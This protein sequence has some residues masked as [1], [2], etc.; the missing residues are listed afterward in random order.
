MSSEIK[1]TN[2]KHESSSSNNLVL[3]S[4][5]SATIN[6]ISST[7]TFPF[8]GTTDAGRVIQTKVLESQEDN[9]L[10]DAFTVRWN[11]SITL[12]SSTS[13]VLVFHYENAYFASANGYG[14]QVY[15]DSS[16]INDS[17]TTFPS[18]T[19][20]ARV[21]SIGGQN[22][23][24]APHENYSASSSYSTTTSFFVDDVSSNFNAGDIVYYGHFYRRN[25]S[26][27]VEVPSAGGGGDGFFRTILMEIQK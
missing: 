14:F 2:I 9:S 23:V 10:N 4:D 6:K 15:R 18:G 17:V 22:S 8:D 24:G 27:T 26:G 5:G 11:Y 21:K 3:A 25:G 13:K 16:V 1:V 7:T 19:N 12:K 20:H